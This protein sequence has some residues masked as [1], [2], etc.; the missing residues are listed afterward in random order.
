[1][2]TDEDI[3]LA[4]VICD[5]M[6]MHHD[7][8]KSD[9]ILVLGTY[10]ERLAIRGAELFFQGYAPLIV[11]SG[12][13]TA[14]AEKNWHETEAEHFSK[15][16]VSMGVP[17]EFILIE[18]K[19]TNT[20]ENINFSKKLLEEKGIYPQSFIIVQKPYMERRSYA[21]FK[22]YWPDKKVLLTSPLVPFDKYPTE[23]VSMER[24][25][26]TIVGD[27]Q[28]IIVYP[29]K[30]FQIYQEVPNNVLNAYTRLV[31]LGYNERLIDN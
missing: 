12:G 20:G 25:I 26:N 18:N 4:K 22:K 10:D 17:E 14:F 7:L 29:E 11:I 19:A 23:E 6:M 31:E 16:M 15:I 24:I 5:Y 27:L 13:M 1:M 28:R 2:V 21:T 30:G 8:K 9:C 3:K